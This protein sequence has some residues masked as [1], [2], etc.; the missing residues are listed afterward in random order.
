M[1]DMMCHSVEVG[2]HLLTAPGAARDTVRVIS[3]QGSVGYLKWSREPHSEALRAQFGGGPN[4]S[5]RP[6]E[7]YARATLTLEDEK[8]NPLVIEAST[9]WAYVGAG[10]RI[11]L[12]LLGS[13]YSMEFSSL[14]PALKVFFSR[15]IKGAPGEDLVEKQNAEQGLMPVVEDEAVTYGYV[16][17]NRHMVECFRRGLTPIETFH[18]GVEVVRIIMGLY[19]SA[20]L[21]RTI[22]FDEEDLENY[23]PVPARSVAKVAA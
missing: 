18:D 16:G 11:D 4:L 12:A 15:A 2:R 10:L 20:E 14:T 23:V 22:L 19:K 9:S 8:G 21:G 17:E 5:E 13:E 6:V 7:D 3:V 1:S